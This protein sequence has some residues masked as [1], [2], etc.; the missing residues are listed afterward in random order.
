[1]PASLPRRPPLAIMAALAFLAAHAA[2]ARLSATRCLVESEREAAPQL[3][4]RPAAAPPNFAPSCVRAGPRSSG[5]SPRRRRHPARSLTHG[6]EER[7][8]ERGVRKRAAAPPGPE[9]SV[10]CRQPSSRS[11]ASAKPPRDTALPAQHPP[12]TFFSVSPA[13]AVAAVAA[14][15]PDAAGATSPPDAPGAALL[16]GLLGLTSGGAAAGGGGGA[17]AAAAGAVPL[18]VLVSAASLI[19]VGS[20]TGARR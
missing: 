1:M 10:R 3:R 12:S 18:A 2:P 9:H 19:L 4:V 14:A 6:S 13:A 17:G 5:G 15:E 8:E 20:R 11:E 16:T 7:G